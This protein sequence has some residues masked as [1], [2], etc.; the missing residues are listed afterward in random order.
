MN[1]AIRLVAASALLLLINIG[2]ASA[3]DPKP[4]IGLVLSGGGAK[5]IAH[6]RVLQALDSLGIVPDYIAGTSMGAVVGGLYASGYTGN[7][8]DSIAN[9]I[10]WT[11]LFSN[12]LS[13]DAINIEEKD[14]FGR[15]IYEMPLIGIKPRFPLGLV[16]GQQIEDLL[17]DLFFHVNR[18]ND[19]DKL[20][21]PFRC[22]TADIVEGVPVVMSKGSLAMAVR[23]SMSI[24]TVF[25]PVVIDGKML[26]DGGVFENLPIETC[27]EMGAEYI[28]AVDVGGGLMSEKEL[29]S[30]LTM[31]LQ[32]TFL[33]ANISYQKEREK[34]DIFVDVV[35]HLRHSTMD[36]E[37]AA[38][39][40]EDGQKA[41][42]DAMPQLI[43]LSENLKNYQQPT[44]KR[45]DIKP[46]RF[47]IESTFTEGV[48]KANEKLVL[49]Q[50]ELTMGDTLTRK[51]AGESVNRLLGTRL[52]DK[53]SY[54]IESENDTTSL[55]IRA[56]ERAVNQAKFALHYDSERGAGVI[57]N[58][59]KR[60]FLLPASR[61]VAT[62]DLAE[63]PTARFNYFYYFG[64]N[65]K[66]WH[67]TELFGER[68]IINSF[69]Q[70]NSVPDGLGRHFAVNTFIN[71]TIN[72]SSYWGFGPALQWNRIRPKI[73]PR[74]QLDV[75]ALEL[76]EYNMSSIGLRSHYVF[77]NLNKVF[78]PSKGTWIRAE[79]RFNIENNADLTLLLTD[80]L[81]RSEAF[82]E[83]LI[84][85]YVRINVRALHVIPTG[86][87]FSVQLL[88]QVGLTQEMSS[89]EN[90]F[91]VYGL[92]AGDFFRVGGELQRPR[93][94]HFP[95]FGL[96]E[97]QLSV[98]QVMSAGARLQW[99]PN[100]NV[101]I[102]PTVNILAAGYDSQ[103]YWNTLGDFQF[104]DETFQGAFYQAGYG[105]N[106]GYMSI[107]GPINIAVF[108]NT[109]TEGLR[110]FFSIGFLL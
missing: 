74:D 63:N 64:K 28:I 23:A 94:I 103:A 81:M 47:V 99:N 67:F 66:W 97:A 52:F 53:I 5:G 1:F 35:K 65:L 50:F 44:I 100:K 17:A 92:G 9:R 83:G 109:V 43:A 8:I 75:N 37:Y 108:D 39:M 40:L 45:P 30:A 51:E 25:P 29:N 20:P 61:L 77:N 13:F 4:K 58:F 60:N 31:L 54:T 27:K 3:Q 91:S 106:L 93:D 10:N 36:F 34:A 59:T 12:K 24:P 96:R 84:Q 2:W 11:S 76:I 105:L 33:A 62:V 107:L 56:K 18:V 89:H 78:Y 72:Q 22:M 85:D 21:I 48:S 42:S 90:F 7:Q 104:S 95:F 55:T 46:V 19:F 87:K 88:G 98:A 68:V 6:I 49:S 14:E 79:L 70:G 71:R 15:Y 69:V 102:S 38:E 32:T 110:W 101:Y 80:S 86:D 82:G 41:L 16:E 26:V 73:G 57:L